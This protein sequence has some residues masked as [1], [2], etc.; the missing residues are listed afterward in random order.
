MP[1]HPVLEFA[2]TTLDSAATLSSPSPN[3]NPSP[4]HISGP[5]LR[6]GTVLDGELL[7]VGGF[8]F[9]LAFDALAVGAQRA[10][11]L[12][13]DG[14]LELM[15]AL[16]LAEAEGCITL[17]ACSAEDAAMRQ[18]GLN[19]A[20][21]LRASRIAEAKNQ[22]AKAAEHWREQA[23][24][25]AAVGSG[26][27][28][29][30]A[31]HKA[32]RAARAA[33][34]AHREAQASL[35]DVKAAGAKADEYQWCKKQQAPAICKDASTVLRKQHHNMIAAALTMLAETQQSCPFHTDGL[36]FG[37]S[38]HVHLE[39]KG[40]AAKLSVCVYT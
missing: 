14:R 24:A 6:P 13:L 32:A 12:P 18:A 16:G 1:Q 31:R 34:A 4:S 17:Q 5:Q 8:F 33:Q 2:P 26:R 3:P 20:V 22:V 15:A 25:A 38:L 9:F 27:T 7:F 23:A 37:P 39:E 11:H 29:S 28:H 19:D 21:V 30:K 10:W 40:E 35:A 36:V